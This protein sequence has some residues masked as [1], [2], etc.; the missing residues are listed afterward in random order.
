MK[1]KHFSAIAVI[2]SSFL[3]L[4]C[5]G[6]DKKKED[7]KANIENNTTAADD[8]MVPKIETA[9]LKDEASILAAMQKV[10][11]A[12][13]ADEKKQKEDPNY[14]GHYTELTSLYTTVL[15]AST[16]F[17][18]TFTDP[19]EALKFNEKLSAITDKMYAK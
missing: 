5:G 6:G 11:D 4:S 10:V 8:G 15:N 7:K 1:L 3:L 13:I 19:A 16:K 12:R 9:A 17:M 18:D 2:V 14:K